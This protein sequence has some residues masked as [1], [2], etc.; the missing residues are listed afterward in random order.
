VTEF[1][2]ETYTRAAA[3]LAE[4]EART[5]CAAAE[6]ERAGALLPQLIV[7]AVE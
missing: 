7:E 2:V 5:R 1:L 6:L 4:T 3:V